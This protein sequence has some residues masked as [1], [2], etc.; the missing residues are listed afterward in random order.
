MFVPLLLLLFSDYALSACVSGMG[1]PAGTIV[2]SSTDCQ[3]AAPVPAAFFDPLRGITFADAATGS[4][5]Y[6]EPPAINALVRFKLL[7]TGPTTFSFGFAAGP[8]IMC[9]CAANDTCPKIASVAG[10]NCPPGRFALKVLGSSA[11]VCIHMRS[12][13]TGVN[14]T[15]TLKGEQLNVTVRLGASYRRL[16]RVVRWPAVVK[17]LKKKIIR[18][19][20]CAS[21]RTA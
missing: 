18:S 6:Y 9:T 12:A 20:A 19:R 1:G 21:S 7:P 10:A 8:S 17:R 11:F 14:T 3:V 4:A 15:V 5:V 16:D 13:P 2:A